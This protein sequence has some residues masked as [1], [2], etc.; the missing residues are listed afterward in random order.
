[1]QLAT[2]ISGLVGN[3]DIPKATSDGTAY[4]LGEGQDA[5][6]TGFGL[7]QISMS[8]KTLGAYTEV[9]R[10]LLQQTSMS[11]EA[12]IRTDLIR[13][14]AQE[15]D[16]KG[17]YG[18]GTEYQPRGLKNYSGIN[19]VDF[20]TTKAPTFAEL[21]KMETEIAADN[22][23]I[24]SMAYVAHSR[25]RGWCK[26]TPKFGT[27]TEATIWEPGNTVNGY[28]TEITNQLL[29]TDVFFGNFADFVIGLWGGLDLTVDP[30]SLSKSGGIRIVAFQ[31]V[32]M[33]LRRPESICWGSDLVS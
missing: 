30:Y 14:I 7:G 32:D 25:F 13:A 21:V 22:A 31:D 23:D 18:L 27:G 10:R 6:E 28:R 16:K 33:A 11:V 8:P 1:M 12:M 15:I 5:T 29:D 17:Y 2:V 9:T 20:A 24:G 3:I 26:T 4:W 19:A